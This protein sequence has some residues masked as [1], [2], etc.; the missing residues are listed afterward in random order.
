M[1]PNRQS[2]SRPVGGIDA[3]SI[4]GSCVGALS[5]ARLPVWMASSQHCWA[6]EIGGVTARRGHDT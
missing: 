6:F 2:V 1:A 5:S 3:E 4:A